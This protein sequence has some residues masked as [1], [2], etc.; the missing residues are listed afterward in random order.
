MGYQYNAYPFEM[1]DHIVY[2]LKKMLDAHDEW[3]YKNEPI[4]LLPFNDGFKPSRVKDA[5]LAE[6]LKYLQTKKIIEMIASIDKDFYNWFKTPIAGVPKMKINT[7]WKIKILDQGKI[8]S[9]A[10]SIE[11]RLKTFNSTD[12]RCDLHFEGGNLYLLVKN[13]PIEL[14][15][16]NNREA[17]DVFQR[18]IIQRIV[19]RDKDGYIM[20][21]GI[22]AGL[23]IGRLSDVVRNAGFKKRARKYLFYRCDDDVIELKSPIYL[24]GEEINRILDDFVT[25]KPKTNKSVTRDTLSDIIG[26]KNNFPS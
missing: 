3:G 7:R 26:G 22:G 13:K 25:H 23:P 24:E 8:R 5:N 10:R 16:F 17:K 15:R 11:V 14:K 12:I 2:V 19:E 21:D 1:T 20:G 18:L 4:Y 6:L 9:L